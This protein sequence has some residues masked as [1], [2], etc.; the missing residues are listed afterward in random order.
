MEM[1]GPEG[2][3]VKVGVTMEVFVAVR[4]SVFVALG[5][6]SV[7]VDVAIMGVDETLVTPITAGVGVKMD[8]VEVAGKKGVG[9]G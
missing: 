8:G 9:P 7:A 3:L 6:K 4:T 1:A 5:R 2:E